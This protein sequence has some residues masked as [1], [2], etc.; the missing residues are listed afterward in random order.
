MQYFVVSL[1]F[2]PIL[3]LCIKKLFKLESIG[4]TSYAVSFVHGFIIC[5]CCEYSI[6][7]EDLWIDDFGA[8]LSPF[9][10]KILSISAAYFLYDTFVC[11]HMKEPVHFLF[12]HL[13][14]FIIF[15][16]C[17]IAQKSGPEVVICLWLGEFSGP[18]LNLRFWF[19]NNKELKGSKWSLLNDVLFCIVFLILRF[20]IGPYVVYYI[21]MQERTL[22]LVKLGSIGFFTI[23]LIMLRLMVR[24]IVDLFSPPK[25]NGK[26][27]SLNKVD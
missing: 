24:G 13:F 14:A 17:L 21:M 5:R 7:T 9:Q 22:L 19:A 11:L 8:A 18:C 15:S 1:L 27:D 25:N 6:Y 20:V 10:F 2:W 4:S 3:C 23:N 16:S 26:D 12:H